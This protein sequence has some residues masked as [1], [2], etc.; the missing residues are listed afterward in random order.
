[1][2]A[3]TG[4]AP[5]TTSAQVKAKR[6]NPREA[7]RAWAVAVLAVLIIAFAVTNLAEVKVKW[8]FGSSRAPLIVVIAISLLV[9][10]VLGHF[11]DRVARRRK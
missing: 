2:S 3:Q 4:Q 10:I 11:A 5:P 9:G 8:I 6:R 7:S 1:M